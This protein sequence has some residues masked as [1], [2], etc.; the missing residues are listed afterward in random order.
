[1]L[2][3]QIM[4][5]PICMSSA[6]LRCLRCHG[7]FYCGRDC[8][9]K[10]W[11]I[12]K[13]DCQRLKLCKQDHESHLR[14]LYEKTNIMN[15]RPDRNMS[16]AREAVQYNEPTPEMRIMVEQYMHLDPNDLKPMASDPALSGPMIRC[17]DNSI[18][19][20]KLTGSKVVGGW[21]FCQGK[22]QV[23]AELHFVIDYKGCYVNVTTDARGE[24]YGG[25]F[26]HDPIANMFVD[27]APP[28]NLMWID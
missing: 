21:M 17:K 14:K 4:I 12:H 19:A 10:H 25:V 7:V 18:A 24:P 26:C 3:L 22:Y 15:P 16:H 1:M 13:L 28:M 27:T 5:C 9:V 6:S 20:A 2:I 11:P 23:E 8:Q